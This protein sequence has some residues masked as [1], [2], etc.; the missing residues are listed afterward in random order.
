MYKI[1]TVKSQAE[2]R[3][4]IQKFFGGVT[5]QE[6]SL[7]KTCL[8]SENQNADTLLKIQTLRT[9]QTNNNVRK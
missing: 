6:M 3:V 1:H 9:E 4:T 7:N 8:Y 5:N 2:T